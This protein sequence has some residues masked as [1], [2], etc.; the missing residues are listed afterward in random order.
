MKKIGMVCLFVA[1]VFFCL[2]YFLN[3]N[4]NSPEL[5]RID[6]TANFDPDSINVPA[7][8][9]SDS[10]D[11]SLNEAEPI[12]NNRK[13]KEGRPL[14]SEYE[15]NEIKKWEG[16]RGY[17]DDH[18]LGDYSA[19]DVVTLERL[20]S[21]G[22]M[23][24]MQLLALE[25][26]KYGDFS[27]AYDLY[28]EAA[29]FGSTYALSAASSLRISQSFI[30]SDVKKK[31]GYLL[32][33]LS[34]L[35]VAERRNDIVINSSYIQTIKDINRVVLSPGQEEVLDQMTDELYKKLLDRREERGVGGFDN[36]VPPEAASLIANIK[37]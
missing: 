19:Y 31:E 12:G 7:S 29:S 1:L 5:V 27:S 15:A 14:I 20:S 4:Q 13:E 25:K 26:T 23:K 34:L 32:D 21:A 37:K 24:A 17:F 10:I 6:A 2:N 22:D 3:E 9:D 8:L 16:S 33:A 30:E 18:Q 35:N 28:L 11:V 36:S